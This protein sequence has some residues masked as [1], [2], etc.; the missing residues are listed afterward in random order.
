MMEEQLHL[1]KFYWDCGRMGDLESLFIASRGQI[2][3]AI[4]KTVYF[5]EVLGKHSDIYGTLEDKDIQRIDIDS[6]S[7][8]KLYN[9]L[10]DYTLSGHNPLEYI[11]TD[12]EDT[13]N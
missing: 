5:G 9:A 8:L 7:V 2:D 1:Y 4:G 12:D 10:G 13:D 11:Q 3:C 6:D